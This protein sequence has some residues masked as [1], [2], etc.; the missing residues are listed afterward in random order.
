MKKASRFNRG[1]TL[2]EVLIVVAIIGILASIAI[3]Y[4]GG[5]VTRS[6]IQQATSGLA[7][8]RVKLEQYFLDNRT[9]VGGGGTW[10]CGTAQ[11][12]ARYFTF[13]CES[14]AS[15]YTVT[16]SGVAGEAMGGFAYTINES[17]AQGSTFTSRPGWKDSATCWVTKEGETC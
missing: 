17:N 6:K 1:F 7:D 13:T 12:T 11:P 15:S 10:K 9:Y 16:A 8:A 3:P 5:Y 14:T 4:Y 2:I